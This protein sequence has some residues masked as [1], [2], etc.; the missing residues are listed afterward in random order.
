MLLWYT[1]VTVFLWTFKCCKHFVCVSCLNKG[2]CTLMYYGSIEN[3]YVSSPLLHMIMPLISY[4][5]MYESK[6]KTMACPIFS[7]CTE[8]LF[9]RST[10][11]P[12]KNI[13]VHIRPTEPLWLR[14]SILGNCIAL[15]HCCTGFVHTAL[16]CT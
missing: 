13:S 9:S 5:S 10:L 12:C 4:I 8:K 7:L 14:S 1:I 15:V 6:G 3:T 16:P 11:F 2:S